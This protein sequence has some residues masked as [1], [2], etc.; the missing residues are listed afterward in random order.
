MSIY[1]LTPD[2]VADVVRGLYYGSNAAAHRFRTSR[3]DYFSDDPHEDGD[4]FYGWHI[5]RLSA[6]GVP[7]G[8][9]DPVAPM[10]AAPALDYVVSLPEGFTLPTNMD[11]FA[12]LGRDY[13]APVFAETFAANPDAGKR[14]CL[15]VST[16]M[17][18]CIPGE[19]GTTAA[20]FSF[21]TG[22]VLQEA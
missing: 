12:A 19:G 9:P 4:A 18:L 21:A 1:H 6:D 11:G 14:L 20:T 3:P 10:L 13:I 15:F 5:M 7:E 8:V 17:M 22:A 16:D 2:E